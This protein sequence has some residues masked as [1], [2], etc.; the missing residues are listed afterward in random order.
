MGKLSVELQV[1]APEAL[2]LLRAHA[3]GA[4]VTVDDVAEDLLSGR[5]RPLELQAGRAAG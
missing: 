3:Y 4:G 1:G 5:L 2:D